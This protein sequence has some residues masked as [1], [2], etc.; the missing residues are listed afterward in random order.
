MFLNKE[1]YYS[2]INNFLGMNIVQITNIFIPL[3]ILPY[4]SRTLSVEVFGF[5]AICL[6]ASYL[7]TQISDLGLTSS[8]P[9]YLSK[10]QKIKSKIEVFFCNGFFIKLF[11]SVFISIIAVVIIY[12]GL[13]NY[14]SLND[15]LCLIVFYITNSLL[16]PWF[17]Q[18][19]EKF[20]QYSIVV[21]VSRCIY[22]S[23]IILYVDN[24]SDLIILLMANVISVFLIL[25]SSIL[26]Y[27]RLGYVFIR[28]C[29]VDIK[30]ILKMSLPFYFSKLVYSILTYSGPILVGLVA[31]VKT[32]AIYNVSEKFYQAGQ[33]L[34][35]PISQAL[36][37]YLSNKKD[38]KVFN[39]L[40]F[41][42]VTIYALG[43]FII[44]CNAEIILYY[45]FGK[46]YV[47]GAFYLRVFM[48]I[49]VVNFTSVFLGFPLFSLLDKM[50]LVYKTSYPG[51][52]ISIMLLAFAYLSGNFSVEYIM[53]S[54]LLGE[55]I[56]LLI[57]LSFWLKEVL[58][59]K[60]NN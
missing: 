15:L 44:A 31:G 48:V 9:Y 8:A 32:V 20:K 50:N 54:I 60:E 16:T 55:A 39:K 19:I 46:E 49:A 5:Y 24:D 30:T 51:V 13:P 3:A 2:L 45:A 57:R 25:V 34:S 42:S 11:S 56:T 53:I 59:V 6:T 58:Y 47:E 14:L 36:Y 40:F 27:K 1:K 10:S 52:F 26:V 18:G 4:L 29:F 17:F 35:S 33:S 22:L 38:W 28:P 43:C 12:F 41:I 7:I 23:V 37:P 21:L